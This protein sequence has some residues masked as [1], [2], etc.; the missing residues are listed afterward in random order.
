MQPED[1][2]AARDLLHVVNDR[3]VAIAGCDQLV[4][5]MR[6]RMGAGGSNQQA[7]P[8][9]EG[10]QF[11]P[12]FH[13]LLAGTLYVVTNLGAELDDRLVH[14]RLDVFFQSDLAVV[15]NLLDV[16]A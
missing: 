10:R 12:Q 13:H 4:H 9:G 16:R 1:K 5:P 2:I 6:K 15:E 14:L 11:A 3:G 7:A 8:R